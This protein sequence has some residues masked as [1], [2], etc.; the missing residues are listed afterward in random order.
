MPYSCLHKFLEKLETLGELHRISVEV[1]PVLEIAEVTDR[2]CK[3]AGG[4]SALLFESVKGSRFPVAT[5]LFGSYNRIC[6]ALEISGTDELSVRMEQ[7]VRSAFELTGF[8]PLRRET[9]LCREITACTDLGGFPI[10]K[11]W[12]NDGGRFITLPLVFT[13]DPEDPGLQNCGMYR[14]R[15]FDGRTLGIHWSAGSGGRSHSERFRRMRKAMPV[16]IAVGGDPAGIWSATLPLPEE[17]DEM[18]FAGYLRGQ[19]VEMVP[20]LTSDLAVPAN[21][22]MIIEG[23]IDP[24]ET[25]E[26]GFF[27][28]HTGYYAGGGPVP[29]M[30]VTSITHR[31]D[32]IYSATVVG[33]PPM[34]NCYMAKAAERLLL[35][36]TRALVPSIADINLPMEGIFHGCA[37]VS[38]RKEYAAQPR[39]VME[40]LWSSGWLRNSR[41][42]VIV[43]GDVDPGNV[44]LVAWKVL[45]NADWERDVTIDNGKFGLDATAKSV[46]R[47]E[48]NRQ[49]ILKDRDVANLVQKKWRLYGW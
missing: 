9:G 32:M 20:C 8:K 3:S 34:E 25:R 18:A 24:E 29:V 21:G 2:V 48:A 15:V 26:E 12:P 33:P 27:G 6:Q 11:S 23:Y 17:V 47:N 42:L 45:N 43:D 1:D 14:V 35:P 44:S 38:I 31:S 7:L 5:N 40:Q 22:E 16:A 36:V 13:H 41:M 37:I 30:H 4:G 46:F 19:P 49:P 39:Q 28:N 10:V